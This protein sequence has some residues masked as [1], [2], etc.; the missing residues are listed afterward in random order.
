MTE[1]AELDKAI[2]IVM[3]WCR[4]TFKAS[5]E[6]DEDTHIEDLLRRLGWPKRR[7]ELTEEMVTRAKH[8]CDHNLLVEIS[9]LE[10]VVEYDD[11]R[12]ILPRHVRPLLE[13]VLC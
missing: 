7:P 8:W 3:G 13:A 9:D 5:D 2:G 1:R 10:T 11:A 12:L 6:M 4:E